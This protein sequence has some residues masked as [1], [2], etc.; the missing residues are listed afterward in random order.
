[1]QPAVQSWRDDLNYAGK[2]VTCVDPIQSEMS[3]K[4]GHGHRSLL[5]CSAMVCLGTP[6]FKKCNGFKLIQFVL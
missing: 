2:W 3:L 5:V 4:G 1:M 6:F